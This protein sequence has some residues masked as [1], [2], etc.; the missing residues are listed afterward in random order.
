[1]AA[2]EKKIVKSEKKN[3]LTFFNSFSLD[4]II[5]PKF[6]T[7]SLLLLFYQNLLLSFHKEH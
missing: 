6:Q 1:M 3:Q 5:P 2:K 7:L 4:K